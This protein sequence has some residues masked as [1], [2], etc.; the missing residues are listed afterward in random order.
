MNSYNLNKKY[1]IL[2]SKIKQHIN[3]RRDILYS[4]IANLCIGK[5][6]ILSHVDL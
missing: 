4:Q 6:L 2:L 5:L 1:K 3:K